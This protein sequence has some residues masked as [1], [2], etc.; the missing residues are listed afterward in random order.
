MWLIIPVAIFIVIIIINAAFN[1]PVRTQLAEHMVCEDRVD[2][3]GILVRRETVYYTGIDGELESVAGEEERIAQGAKIAAIYLPGA[4]NSV[5]E[6]LN[7]INEEI[8]AL[9]KAIQRSDTI[10]DD[11]MLSDLQV[12]SAVNEIIGM[13]GRGNYS[14]IRLLKNEVELLMNNRSEDYRGEVS[15][16]QT[17]LEELESRK[18]YLENEISSS[19][20]DIYSFEGG[21][22]SSVIDGYEE[23]LTIDSLESMTIE[24]F[25]SML[26]GIPETE[27]HTNKL[28]AGGAACKV[29]DNSQWRLVTLMSE[30]DAYGLRQGRRI[31]LRVT[32]LSS[33][34]FPGTIEHISEPQDGEVLIVISANRY[35]ET[36]YSARKVEVAVI[37][38]TYEG[39]AVPTSAIRSI[40]G[41]TGVF[42]NL[43]GAARFRLAEEIYKKDGISIIKIDDSPVEQGQNK[44]LR[45][46]D[47]VIVDGKDINDGK[48]VN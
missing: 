47:K 10:N 30:K 11:V 19:K 9:K 23:I 1:T 46:Y 38:N 33:A 4:D 3:S 16:R 8:A 42:I 25:K 24:D 44:Y 28:S 18:A 39:M 14:G 13:A 31:R 40:N 48:V 27:S 15:Q 36:I 29:V 41:K 45:I 12:K 26:A 2:L 37:K 35:I 21:V 17:R 34:T 20:H 22:Y 43:N 5:R 32:S 7:D 6:E